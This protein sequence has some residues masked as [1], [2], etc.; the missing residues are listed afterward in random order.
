MKKLLTALLVSML[1][2]IAVSGCQEGDSSANGRAGMIAIDNLRLE[3]QEKDTEIAKLTSQL[4][5]CETKSKLL[6]I[7]ST[8][9]GAGFMEIFAATNQKTIKLEKENAA[10]KARIKELEKK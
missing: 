2:T 9:A 6:E 7:Q 3:I 4:E 1:F 8:K 5:K 10:L